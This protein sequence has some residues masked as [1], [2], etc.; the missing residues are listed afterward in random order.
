MAKRVPRKRAILWTGPALDDLREI[1]RYVARDKPQAARALAR[2]IRERVNGLHE[3]PQSGR[4]VPE[5]ERQ[6]LLEMI[7][8]P[9]RIV[10]QTRQD[11]IVILRVWH[12]HRD[13]GRAALGVCSD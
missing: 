11:A 2:R 10:Y 9:Y 8:A 12:G 4:M 6:G 13:L 5:L 3:H 7:V 1:Q